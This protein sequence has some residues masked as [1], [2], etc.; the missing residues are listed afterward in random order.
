LL[1]VTGNSCGQPP[2]GSDVVDVVG[3]PDVVLP[4]AVVPDV[5][6]VDVDG[7]VVVE[8]DVGG[9]LVTCV[10]GG[11]ILVLDV[12][13]VRVVDVRLVGRDEEC[14]FVGDVGDGR[15]PSDA[16]GVARVVVGGAVGPLIVLGPEFNQFTAS[17]P[18]TITTP[19]ASSANNG[20]A[21]L[22]RSRRGRSS[23]EPGVTEIPPGAVG[24][25]NGSFG[26]PYPLPYG[27]PVN[28]WPEYPWPP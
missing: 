19:R 8:V 28:G 10:G 3:G 16:V 6:V 25:R 24:V 23:P 15:T 12:V 4:G 18:S 14:V 2:A 11:T 20:T 13:V 27:W 26:P 7:L 5:E 1:S 21:T 17:T 22:R 9:V